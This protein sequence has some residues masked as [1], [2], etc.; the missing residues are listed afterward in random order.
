MFLLYLTS[1]PKLGGFLMPNLFVFLKEVKEELLKVT[2][3][4]RQ[5]TIRYTALVIIVAVVV[6]ALLA[7]LDYILT[8]FTAFI[9]SNY[10][11]R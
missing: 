4:N 2:W 8:S 3:P 6:G 7:G 11:G 10:H 5:Q 9:V 1:P